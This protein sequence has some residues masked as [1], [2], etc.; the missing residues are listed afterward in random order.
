MLMAKPLSAVATSLL[1]GSACPALAAT[2]SNLA[3]EAFSAQT[4]QGVF[5]CVSNAATGHRQVLKLGGKEIYRQ[6]PQSDAPSETDLL[7]DGI[8]HRDIGCPT[9][10]ASS[11]GYVLMVRDLQPPQYQTRGYLLADF[12]ED[13]PALIDLGTGQGP[14]DDKIEDKQRL[15]WQKGGFVLNYFGYAP[16]T[17]TETQPTPE[18]ANQTTLF[19]FAGNQI[20]N[21]KQ[22]MPLKGLPMFGE[23]AAKLLKTDPATVLPDGLRAGATKAQAMAVLRRY[24]KPYDPEKSDF[25]DDSDLLTLPLCGAAN[26]E[27]MTTFH[28]KSG[29]LDKIRFLTPAQD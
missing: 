10:L 18:P 25:T 17:D 13:T 23:L 9:V 28:F 14:Q 1:L 6:S 22:C 27:I 11:D 16:G 26:E 2:F 3:G 21:G 29:T 5:E 19:T 24:G 4:P 20:Q 8:I 15:S 7:R 12:N